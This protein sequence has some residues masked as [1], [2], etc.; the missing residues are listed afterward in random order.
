[1]Q[2]SVKNAA[3]DGGDMDS[4]VLGSGLTLASLMGPS[5][6]SAVRAVLMKA[7]VRI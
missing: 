6:N 3:K 5:L 4:L 1:M 7:A 2:N